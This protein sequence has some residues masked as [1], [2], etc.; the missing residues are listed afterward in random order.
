M[1]QSDQGMDQQ[2]KQVKVL[3]IHPSGPGRM[4]GWLSGLSRL[5]GK[6]ALDR[7]LHSSVLSFDPEPFWG[8]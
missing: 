6:I 7:A 5:E 8:V 4:N 3:S 2:P 1:R